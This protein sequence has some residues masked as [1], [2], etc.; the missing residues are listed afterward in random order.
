MLAHLMSDPWAEIIVTAYW[1]GFVAIGY[2]CVLYPISQRLLRRF[3]TSGAK[4]PRERCCPTL[5][6]PAHNE[7]SVLRAKLENALALNITF[8]DLEIIVA[9]DGS[10]DRTVEIA[11][12]FEDRGVRVLAFAKRRGK[13]SVVND[14]VGQARGDVVCLCDANVMFEPDALEKLVARLGDP[15]VGAVTG[16]VRIASHESNFGQGESSYYSLERRLQIAESRVG[17]LMGVDG[18]MY[19]LRKELFRP[20]P[21]DTIL[22]DFVI[23]MQVIRQGYR[24]VY[25]PS[26]VAHENGTPTA[27]Q[28]WRRRVRVAAG[29]MQSVLRRQWPP[30]TRPVELW[31]YLS[32]KALRWMMPGFLVVLFVSN[33][34]LAPAHLFYQATLVGQCVLY[35][36]AAGGLVSLRFRR[37]RIGG[38]AFYFVMSN[39]AMAVGLVKGLFNR[40]PVTWQQADRTAVQEKTPTG[41]S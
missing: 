31:Q 30:V 26:A 34:L 33:A 38:I 5:I 27:T 20:L 15:K 35:F 37:T 3:E 10:R 19:V 16:E 25:E 18:G 22:D 9:S 7:E 29:A 28:E 13:A 4:V 17:S 23:S 40:Q 12:A 11:R 1:M 36:M 6:I 2:V 21:A 14:A 24:V 32:H 8:D 39:V 41:A